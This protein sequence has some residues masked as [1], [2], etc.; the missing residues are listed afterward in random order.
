MAL[1][2]EKMQVLHTQIFLVRRFFRIKRFV[3]FTYKK[4]VADTSDV[5]HVEGILINID[6]TFSSEKICSL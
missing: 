4:I 2:P 3:F 5:S 6:T 1:I